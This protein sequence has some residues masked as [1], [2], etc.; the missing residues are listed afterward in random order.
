MFSVWDHA[1]RVYKYYESPEASAA[2]SAPKPAHLRSATLGMSPEE[3]A[4]PLPSNAK[5]VGRGKYPRG[6]IASTQ[7]SGNGL[8]MIDFTPGNM[9]LFGVVGFMTWRFLQR[10]R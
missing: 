10:R 1:N 3:A 8:G 5:F 4:W 6:Q 7:S 2:T 9:F